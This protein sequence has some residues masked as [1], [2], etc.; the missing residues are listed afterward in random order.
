MQDEVITFNVRIIG[1]DNSSLVACDDDG[2]DL[3][4]L[5]AAV[6]DD[7]RAKL[8]KRGFKVATEMLIDGVS[9]G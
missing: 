3:V 2:N 5:P 6:A 1:Y 8:L 4:N 7:W 9:H